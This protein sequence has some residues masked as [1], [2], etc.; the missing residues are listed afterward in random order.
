[1]NGNFYHK[2]KGSSEGDANALVKNLREE[3]SKF[4]SDGLS[5]LPANSL[6]DVAEKLG[7]H[8]KDTGLKT[9]QIRRFLDGIRKLDVQFNKGK[10]FLEDQV[11]LLKPKLAYAAGRNQSVR[12]LMEV[13][14]PAIAGAGKS[15]ADF[16]KL[17]SFIEAIV[18]YHK[19]YGGAD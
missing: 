2:K 19:F 17:L 14:Q 9:T 8:L 10:D 3:I 5:K 1:M 18:A 12:P 16:K 13:L 4:Q 6:V 15:Y 7:K 11:V